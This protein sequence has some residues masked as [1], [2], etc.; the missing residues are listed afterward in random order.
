MSP[1]FADRDIVYSARYYNPPGS[2]KPTSHFHLYRINPDGTGRRQLTF[3]RQDDTY[4]KWSPNGR[5]ILF[6]RGLHQL[7]VI[8][9]RGG[10]VHVIAGNNDFMLADYG[11]ASWWPIGNLVF[12]SA[13]PRHPARL[14]DIRRPRVVAVLGNVESMLVSPSGVFAWLQFRN[15]AGAIAGIWPMS[16]RVVARCGG[17]DLATWVAPNEVAVYTF[18]PAKD[19][20]DTIS[21]FRISGDAV[22]Q[23]SGPASGVDGWPRVIEGIPNDSKELLVGTINTHYDCS[24]GRFDLSTHRIKPWLMMQSFVAFQPEDGRYVTARYDVIPY[25]ASR[26]VWGG[27]MS[28]GKAIDDT[29]PK[30]IVRGLVCIDGA[31]WR[32]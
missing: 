19:S 14:I 29:N 30:P 2:S 12:L 18:S 3:G 32:R 15:G 24:Y 27:D 16:Y 10:R 6:Q 20:S 5:W 23:H 22:L 17:Y 9:S 28:V 25:G 8:S 26:Q 1:T 31:D 13:S 21:T 4:P 11:D 7:C